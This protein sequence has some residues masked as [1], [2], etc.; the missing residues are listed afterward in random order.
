MINNSNFFMVTSPLQDNYTIH[1]NKSNSKDTVAM[2]VVH[3]IL[4]HQRLQMNSRSTHQS[5]E[6]RLMSY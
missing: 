6:I 2:G 4:R 5:Q 3:F 1:K